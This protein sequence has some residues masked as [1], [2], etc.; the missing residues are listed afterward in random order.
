MANLTSYFLI[1]WILWVFWVS[2]AVYY[3][4]TRQKNGIFYS[5][6]IALILTFGVMGFIIEDS[7]ENVFPHPTIL[8]GPT[9]LILQ[10]FLISILL[11]VFLQ[12]C[13]WWFTRRWHR[14]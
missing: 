10:H 3:K 9:S 7:P 13:V 2:F 4:W 12:L 6:Y 11:T 5:L 8:S 14:K 1:L